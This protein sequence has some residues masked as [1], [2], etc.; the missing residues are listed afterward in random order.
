MPENPKALI[1]AIH[2]LRGDNFE[3]WTHRSKKQEMLWLRDLLPK[4]SSTKD[5]AIYTFGWDADIQ[6]QS[7]GTLHDVADRFLEA[8]LNLNQVRNLDVAPERGVLV[9]HLS[10]DFGRRRRNSRLQSY[11]FATVSGV[12]W[13][14]WCEFLIIARFVR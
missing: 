3:S 11:L 2:G 13:P 10:A 1:V 12:S 6:T 4:E 8:L 14:K 7:V 9:G 5:C